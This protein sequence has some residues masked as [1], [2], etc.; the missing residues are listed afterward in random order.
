MPSRIPPR[1]AD[2]DNSTDDRFWQRFRLGPGNTDTVDTSADESFEQTGGGGCFVQS[3]G[4]PFLIECRSA[5]P[6]LR[7]SIHPSVCNIFHRFWLTCET[8][9]TFF[10]LQLVLSLSRIVAS[11]FRNCNVNFWRCNNEIYSSKFTRGKEFRK[12]LKNRS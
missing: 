5:N 4:L 9:R 6:H 10:Y 12:S 1:N 8:F 2:P 11:K 7:R 3:R